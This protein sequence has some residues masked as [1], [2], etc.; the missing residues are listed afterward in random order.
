VVSRA[1]NTANSHSSEQGTLPTTPLI[2]KQVIPYRTHGGTH[3]PEVSTPKTHSLADSSMTIHITWQISTISTIPILLKPQYWSSPRSPHISTDGIPTLN[4][5]QTQHHKDE[6]TCTT[7]MT[8]WLSITNQVWTQ[9]LKCEDYVTI[10]IHAGQCVYWRKKAYMIN[11]VNGHLPCF[12][13]CCCSKPSLRSLESS[14]T[15]KRLNSD[16]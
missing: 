6:K 4:T 15:T 2:S 8:A 12:S 10:L 13:L 3:C 9:I 7:L 1:S 11:M 14:W 16:D 5:S